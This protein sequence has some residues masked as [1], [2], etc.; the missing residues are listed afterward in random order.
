MLSFEPLFSEPRCGFECGFVQMWVPECFLWMFE[1]SIRPQV[2]PGPLMPSRGNLKTVR[3]DNHPST[4]FWEYLGPQVPYF[5]PKWFLAMGRDSGATWATRLGRLGSGRP[6]E[7]ERK[8]GEAQ[9]GGRLRSGVCSWLG[10]LR[11][12][13]VLWV[14]VCVCV[15]FFFLGGGGFMSGNLWLVVWVGGIWIW[16]RSH[17]SCRV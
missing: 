2:P 17:G 11:G 3:L 16:I 9:R 4:I 6:G 1:Q 5:R 13:L 10:G 15:F 14:C 12:L 7:G 8:N